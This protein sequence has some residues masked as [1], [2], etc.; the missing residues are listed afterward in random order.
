VSRQQHFNV[1]YGMFICSELGTVF[2]GFS[3]LCVCV[4]GGGEHPAMQCHSQFGC[5]VC[6]FTFYCVH[7]KKILPNN[8]LV[9]MCNKMVYNNVMGTVWLNCIK[10]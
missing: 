6:I 9:L 10:Y 8:F 7:N 4:G 1:T 2:V 3:S 5:R